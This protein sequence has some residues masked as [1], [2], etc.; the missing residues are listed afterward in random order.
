MIKKSF[1]SISLAILAVV[2]FA[3][4]A[5]AVPIGSLDIGI[6]SGGGVTVSQTVI[7]WQLP[8]GPPN[9]CIVTGT[10]TNV[11]SSFG[12]LGPGVTGTIL[13]L[14]STTTVLPLSNFMQL[15]GLNFVLTALGPGSVNT[16]CPNSTSPD[17]PAC[18]VFAGSPF[19]LTAN[20]SGTAVTLPASGTVSD[21]T[22][23]S[24]W[25]GAYTTQIAGL[26]PAQVQNIIMVQ[27]GSVNST[28]SGDFTLTATAIPEPASL[29]LFGTG[30]VGLAM[31]ARKRN[32]K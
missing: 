10:H 31:R 1:F 23:T 20:R 26:T 22:G 17:A 30:L 4:T 27:H 8:V 21:A 32:R 16:L 13:D 12:T 5:S 15:G 9:G 24:I 11:T 18:S 6:C 7:D 19:I 14:D 2:M 29:T 25:I 28:E 3:A